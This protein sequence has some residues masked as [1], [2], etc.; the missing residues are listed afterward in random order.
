[1]F[2]KKEFDNAILTKKKI[3]IPIFRKNIYLRR[4]S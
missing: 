2:F 3:K 4:T 1:M